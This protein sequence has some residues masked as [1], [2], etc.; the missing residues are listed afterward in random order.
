MA[1]ILQSILNFY[2]KDDFFNWQLPLV[3]IFCVFQTLFFMLCRVVANR[4]V[5]TATPSWCDPESY[6]CRLV[7]AMGDADIQYACIKTATL[8]EM[9]TLWKSEQALYEKFRIEG[10]VDPGDRHQVYDVAV[11]FYSSGAIIMQFPSLENSPAT[12]PGILISNAA[13]EKV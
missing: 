6:Q 11:K 7:A 12:R 5:S 2:Y 8:G 13:G 9:E 3:G 4:H 10:L 1:T